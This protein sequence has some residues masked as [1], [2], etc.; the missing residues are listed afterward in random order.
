MFCS[1]CGK[2][3]GDGARFCSFCGKAVSG[4]VIRPAQPIQSV[5]P[6]EPV[7]S[8]ETFQPVEQAAAGLMGQNVEQEKE[9]IS[10]PVIQRAEAAEQTEQVVFQSIEQTANEFFGQTVE[11]ERIEQQISE[12]V[13]PRAEVEPVGQN[14][15]QAIDRPI[16]EQALSQPTFNYRPAETV[17]SATGRQLNETPWTGADMTV[18]TG[19]AANVPNVVNIPNV[20]TKKEPERKYTFAHLMMCLASTAIF[21]IAAGIFAG[22]YFAGL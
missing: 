22:L 2:Q 21:A 4:N 5:Q 3:L 13:M 11:Q 8:V 16:S 19:N 9:Q 7:Q 18:N 10:E 1:Y 14:V 15:E 17:N 12:P 6:V 20:P